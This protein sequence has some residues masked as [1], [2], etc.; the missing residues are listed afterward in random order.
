MQPPVRAVVP[1]PPERSTAVPRTRRN[2]SLQAR[3]PSTLPVSPAIAEAKS[4][5]PRFKRKYT[6]LMAS[7]VPV[8]LLVLGAWYFFSTHS[9]GKLSAINIVA[10]VAKASTGYVAPL[11]GQSSGRTNILVYGMTLDGMRT[12]SIMLVSYYWQQKKLVTLNIPR[13]LYVYDGYEN[14]KF[15]EVYSYSKLR[16]PH[17]P[18]YPPQQVA[19]LVSKEYGIP[20]NYWVS[21]NMK[22]EIQLVNT[23]G[24]IDIN[25]PDSFTDYEYPT[26]NYSGYVRPAPHF[27]AGLQHMDGATALEYSRSRHSLDNG[28]G[29]DFA[30]SKRQGLVLQAVMTKVKAMG[31]LGNLTDISQYLTILGNNVDTN[32]T[33]DEMLSFAKVAKSI[34]P[35]ADYTIG[36]WATGNGFLCSSTS[37]YGAYITLYGV[38][39]NCGTQVNAGKDSEYREL[40]IYYVNNLLTA[41]P[42]TGPQFLS[43]A[44][45]QLPAPY[46]SGA[47]LT[48]A[49]GAQNVDPSPSTIPSASP[50]P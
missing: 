8:L 38:P 5:R 2:V 18:T 24:G 48:T 28:E 6:I 10:S 45:P 41:A 23:L 39:G 32:M 31:L 43:L 50:S 12:D 40:A 33:T 22:G 19:D 17:N 21:L 4:T 34:D 36:N 30:R 16:Q 14:A 1:R 20:I 49:G 42:L 26:W 25:V 46:G 27:S 37:S 3:P 9:K 29:T 44:L 7:I 11:A 35:H 15:G 47:P 13:D